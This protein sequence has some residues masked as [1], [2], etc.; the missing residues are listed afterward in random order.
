MCPHREACTSFKYPDDGLLQLWDV[1]QE[2]ELCHPHM[3]DQDG[4]ECLL[5]IKNGNA[6]GLTI[7]RLTGIKSLSHQENP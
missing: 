1:I 5:V 2:G 7:S 6:T 3:L 4:E